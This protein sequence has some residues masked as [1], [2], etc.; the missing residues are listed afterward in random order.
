MNVTAPLRRLARIIPDVPAIIRADDSAISFA[1]LDR[2]IDAVARRL[3]EAGLRAGETIGLG[4]T[5]PDESRGLITA[6]ALARLGIASSHPSLPAARRI[7]FAPPA[8]PGDVAVGDA[9]F[10]PD[11]AEG[12]LDLHPGGSAL[13]RR[14]AS[15]GT[16]GRAKPIA[17]SHALQAARTQANILAP[18]GPSPCV[19][20][21][22]VDLG[23][24]WG[25]TGALRTLW[26]GGT[27]VLTNP[28]AA[29]RKLAQHRVQSLVLAPVGLRALLDA[30]PAEAGP[31]EDLFTIEVGGDMIAPTLRRAASA[32][33][34]PVLVSYLGASEAGGIASAPLGA[35]RGAADAVGFVHPGVEVQVV[36]P[37]GHALPHG[38]PGRVRVRGELVVNGY[39]GEAGG[40]GTFED[41]WFYPGDLGSLDA[42]GLLHLAGREG[43][44]LNLGGVKVSARSVEAALLEMPGVTDAA[45]FMVEDALGVP[46]L[47]AA[48]VGP[49]RLAREAIEAF[50]RERLRDSFPRAVVQ[51]PALPRNEAGKVRRNMLAA[52]ARRGAGG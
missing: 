42:D 31:F 26:Q 51:V 14:F 48:V 18:G 19:R 4:I 24:T 16:T 7:V 12:P 8:Q 2:T 39:D 13:L 33:L 35:L 47:W 50:C 52:L 40:G 37:A 17:V 25:F 32:R 20:I 36:D 49:E 15:S 5:G 41:G 43:D 11:P 34:G 30:L 6:L 9:A 27:L 23:I 28:A 46:T 10:V 21:V 29:A 22:G 3:L 44:V 38:T 1:A 45:A